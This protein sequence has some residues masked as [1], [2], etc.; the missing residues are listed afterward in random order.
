[1]PDRENSAMYAKI[2]TDANDWKAINF[3]AEQIVDDIQRSLSGS[4]A[5]PCFGCIETNLLQTG[6]CLRCKHVKGCNV[7]AKT[8]KQDLS[9]LLSA[10]VR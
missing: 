3:D 4:F 2:S 9:A 7:Y 8:L 10:A 1:M 5:P 6:D